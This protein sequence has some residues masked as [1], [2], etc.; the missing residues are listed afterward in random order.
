MA[1]EGPPAPQQSPVAL[2]AVPPT[3]RVHLP[4]PPTQQI[5]PQMPHLNW[6]HF[7]PEYSGKPEEDT[8][9]HL[10]WM[11]DWME[12]HAFPEVVKVQRFCLT[13]VGEARPWYES[14]RP[15]AVD[16]NGLQD[17]LRQYY[18]KIGNTQRQLFHAWNS[19]HYDENTEMIGTYVTRIRQVVA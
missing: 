11:N 14:H 8:E 13:L 19:F 9:A 6:S 16:W 5:Q 1:D 2:A 10:H 18:S 7:K 4:A 15:I 17:K 12:T 3:P